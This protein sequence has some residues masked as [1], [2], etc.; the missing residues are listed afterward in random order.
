MSAL[1]AGWTA[2]RPLW[3]L[4]R[5][6]LLVPVLAGL[7]FAFGYWQGRQA[8]GEADLRAALD[9]ARRDL[10]VQQSAAHAAAQRAVERERLLR[11]QNEWIDRYAAEL[12]D[13]ADQCRL[14]PDDLERLRP[15]SGA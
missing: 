7:L 15:L 10:A 8:A 3:R 9:T 2:A 5:G 11:D 12:M 14:S 1:F 13:R 6:P 4:L